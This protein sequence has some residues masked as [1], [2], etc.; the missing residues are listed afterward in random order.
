MPVR[1]LNVG[2][3]PK[4]RCK[5]FKNSRDPENQTQKIRPRRAN[6]FLILFQIFLLFKRNIKIRPTFQK[7]D[8]S[9]KT[10]VLNSAKW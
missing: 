10:H 8:P 5:Q 4:A 2:R 7:S 6:T 1:D 3:D 9:N